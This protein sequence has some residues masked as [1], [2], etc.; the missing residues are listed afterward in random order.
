MVRPPTSQVTG[1]DTPDVVVHWLRP[2]AHIIWFPRPLQTYTRCLRAVI[3]HG[4]GQM[5]QP[6]TSQVTAGKDIP[7]V[8]WLRPQAHMEWFPHPLQVYTRCLRAVI[9]HAHIKQWFPHPLQTCTQRLRTYTC[10]GCRQINPPSCHF[11]H[12]C[13]PQILGVGQLPKS[14]VKIHLMLR[15]IG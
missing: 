4:W 7:A 9:C 10:C 5:G 11:H 1:K 15:C 6:P 3:C 8:H 14:Q 12:T 2:Q 13:W